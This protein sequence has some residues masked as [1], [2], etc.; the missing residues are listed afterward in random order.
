MEARKN[1]ELEIDKKRG[2]FFNIGLVISLLFVISAFEWQFEK[3]IPEADLPNITEWDEPVIIPITVHTPKIPVPPIVKP[4]V[5][6][7]SIVSDEPMKEVPKEYLP[8]II[9]EP[10]DD[11][12]E[13]IIFFKGPPTEIDSVFRIV[14]KF[15]EPVGGYD[16]FYHHLS[17]KIKY[18]RAIGHQI[19]GWVYVEFVVDKDGSLTEQK[20]VKGIGF[21]C[22]EEVLS[23]F[24]DVPKWHPG[25]QRGVPV[26]VKMV[27]PVKF[28]NQ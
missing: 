11:F 21:G 7:S 1:K 9:D 17:K 20:I 5:T 8:D 28:Q 19:N 10:A 24:A 23:A 13:P 25:K 3:T 2:L 15:P 22:D 14:Q 27:L 26:K 18:H 12:I 16:A 4:P 6:N